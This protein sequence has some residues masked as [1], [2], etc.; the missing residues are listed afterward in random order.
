MFGYK[1]KTTKDTYPAKNF[2]QKRLCTRMYSIHSVLS[3]LL[4]V[5]LFYFIKKH[6]L[7]YYTR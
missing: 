1:Q 7:S 2:N 6:F 3:V 4:N 5:R